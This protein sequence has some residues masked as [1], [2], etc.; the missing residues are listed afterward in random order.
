MKRTFIPED[1]IELPK[2]TDAKASKSYTRGVI[3]LLWKNFWLKD[4]ATTEQE[5]FE[6]YPDIYGYYKD[7]SIRSEILEK[8]IRKSAIYEICGKKGRRYVLNP[9]RTKRPDGFMYKTK[10]MARID[11]RVEDSILQTAIFY[12]KYINEN[13]FPVIRIGDGIIDNSDSFDNAM[14]DEIILHIMSYFDAIYRKFKAKIEK[15]PSMRQRW[16]FYESASK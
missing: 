12:G 5:L 11:E 14:L 1:W 10:A 2:H 8:L 9:E 3:S 15:D 4:R 16:R 7:N 6:L 13:Q